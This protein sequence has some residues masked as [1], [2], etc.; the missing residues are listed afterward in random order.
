MRQHFACRVITAVFFLLENARQLER[1]DLIRHFRLDLPFEEHEVTL[2]VSEFF[3]DFVSLDVEHFRQ[4]LH[5]LFRQ[6]H[7]HFRR[8]GPDRLNRRRNRQR[9]AIAVE[10]HATIGLQFEH[11]A[12]ARLTLILQKIAMKTL[13]IGSAADQR[14]ESDPQCGHQ[15]VAAPLRKAN[16]LVCVGRIHV[17]LH[18]EAA[19]PAARYYCCG[20]GC[21]GIG[22]AVV[23]PGIT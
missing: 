18:D 8:T 5:L 19:K 10:N 3:L 20:C 21:A 12:V 14:S 13:Q 7:F 22:A 4:R 16:I 11:A 1:N 15:R 6:R 17:F 23:F 2:L 9:L